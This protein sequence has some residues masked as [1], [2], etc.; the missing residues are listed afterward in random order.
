MRKRSLVLAV[1]GVS[2]FAGVSLTACSGSGDENGQAASSS[3]AS[4]DSTVA[5][6]PTGDT[7]SSGAPAPGP[8]GDDSVIPNISSVVFPNTSG[9][10]IVVVAG[11]P[12]PVLPSD[13]KFT[14]KAWTV[15]VNPKNAAE[16]RNG[17]VPA[18]GN[19]AQGFSVPDIIP[20]GEVKDFTVVI[21]QAGGKPIEVKVQVK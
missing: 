14:E 11:Q 12:N 5:P 1:A 17:Q 16:V 6:G 18:A 8:T 9:T 13:F 4:S 20:T 15:T 19:G 7:S 2:I 10:P 3:A 21:T